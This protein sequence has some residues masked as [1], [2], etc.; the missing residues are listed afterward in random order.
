MASRAAERERTRW[1]ELKETRLRGGLCLRCGEI[2]D[3]EGMTNKLGALHTTCTRCARREHCGYG[4]RVPT[5]DPGSIEAMER[6]L[7]MPVTGRGGRDIK[8]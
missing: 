7:G 6:A 4:E 5:E 2:N 1:R 8:K 3:R